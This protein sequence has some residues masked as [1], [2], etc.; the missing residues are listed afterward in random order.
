MR[1]LPCPAAA[2]REC[3]GLWIGQDVEAEAAV[4]EVEGVDQISEKLQYLGQ[5]NIGRRDGEMQ[6]TR[7]VE[8]EGG[9]DE[10]D[11]RHAA[12]AQLPLAVNRSVRSLRGL[13]ADAALNVH[14]C[15]EIGVD[16]GEV[17][18]TSAP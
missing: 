6:R 17:R 2:D 16:E 14:M 15:F 3:T 4:A 12:D 5:L 10:S 7:F 9:I 8:A 1:H 13:L 18:R 11:Q